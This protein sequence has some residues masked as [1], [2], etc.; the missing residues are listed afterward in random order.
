MMIQACRLPNATWPTILCIDDDPQ[1]P[2]TIGLR[3]NQYEV[4]VLRA[5][6]GMHGFWLAMTGHPGVIITDV[7]M[8]QGNGDYIVDC[9]RQNT[10]TREIPIIVLTGRRE[11]QLER[12]LRH[13]GADEF[14]VKPVHFDKLRSAI[15]KYIPLNER[16]WN[17]VRTMVRQ[18]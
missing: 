5:G 7:N 10:D 14:F 6:Y 13:S 15:L 12:R 9:L 1:I 3:L 2:E 16:N 18:T 8:P 17:E 4:N 11:E